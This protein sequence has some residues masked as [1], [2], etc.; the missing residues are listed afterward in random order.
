MNNFEVTVTNKVRAFLND[1]PAHIEWNG[2]SL[3]VRTLY[4]NEAV[5]LC[6]MLEDEFGHMGMGQLGDTGEWYFDFKGKDDGNL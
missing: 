2:G 1:I 3:F 5:N 6:A 4:D